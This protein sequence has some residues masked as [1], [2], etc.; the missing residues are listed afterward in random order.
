MFLLFII[1]ILFPYC[2]CLC[3]FFLRCFLRLF[4]YAMSGHN[5]GF[6]I[7]V[8][9]GKQAVAYPVEQC[10]QFPYLRISQF[11][12]KFLINLSSFNFKEI[13]GDFL[14]RL[15]GKDDINS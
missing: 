14:L 9:K 12:E 1:E 10:T 3:Y 8:P 6:H 11:F 15:Y 5:Q 2:F 7:C 13:I 4:D